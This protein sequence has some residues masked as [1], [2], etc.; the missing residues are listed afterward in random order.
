MGWDELERP[1]VG[2][3]TVDGIELRAG[4]RVVLRPAPG[5]DI[6][7]LALADRVA[8]VQALEQELDGRV[9]LA[10]TL[11]D[12]PGRA[13]GEARFLGH[14]FF[15]AADEVEPLHDPAPAS[16][17]GPPTPRVLVAG[18]GNVFLGDDGFGVALATRLAEQRLPPGV[19]VVDFGIRGMDLV[20]A[21]QRDYDVAVF[22]DATARGEAPGTLSVIEVGADE[23]EA[24]LDTHGMDPVKVLG[25]ARALG[26]VPP[27]ILV[28]GCEPAVLVDETSEDVLVQ[29]SPPVEGALDEA[30]R[31][32]TSLLE[33]L[34]TTDQRE[35][36]P[37]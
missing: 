3:V 34:I 6:L 20:Y 12:D 17:S 29:L 9:Q 23:G 2:S 8:I 21:L 36:P 32:A 10:V 25:F 24:S 30:T 1:T 16:G 7:D 28:L 37:S 14:R 11:E 26:P 22:L 4:S 19:D 33:E 35:V 27:R 5:R 18:V 13:L 15:F 31:L